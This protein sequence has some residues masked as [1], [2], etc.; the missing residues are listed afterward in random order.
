MRSRGQVAL[1][2]TTY[3]LAWFAVASYFPYP[4]DFHSTSGDKSGN[5][6]FC[7]RR[8]AVTRPSFFRSHIG[9]AHKPEQEKSWLFPVV[10]EPLCRLSPPRRTRLRGCTIL[11]RPVLSVPRGLVPEFP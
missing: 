5:S 8:S 7:S 1:I 10:A 2:S 6:P 4:C 9:G 3:P 11:H